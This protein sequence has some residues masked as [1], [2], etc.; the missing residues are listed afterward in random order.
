MNRLKEC[1]V[2]ICSGIKQTYMHLH[3]SVRTS[4]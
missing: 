1:E 3:I 2:L 4:V